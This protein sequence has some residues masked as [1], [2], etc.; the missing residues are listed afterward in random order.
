[1][2]YI[3]HVILSIKLFKCSRVC[4]TLNIKCD[5]LFLSWVPYRVVPAKETENLPQIKYHVPLRIIQQNWGSLQPVRL[6]GC[7]A[8]RSDR[9]SVHFQHLMLKCWTNFEVS[10]W[11]I[12]NE[13]RK[14]GESRVATHP[15]TCCCSA[16]LRHVAISASRDPCPQAQPRV[17][18]KPTLSFEP[19]GAT[20]VAV[21]L[22]I[23]RT[24]AVPLLPKRS[25][26]DEFWGM[27]WN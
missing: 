21:Q 26:N 16:L 6:A 27:L 12:E 7:A 18:S 22:K 11:R 3:I 5:W 4:G 8:A 25:Q 10:S 19:L 1:M 17:A 14:S 13:T 23:S 2:P 15:T 24:P 9:P 20:Q